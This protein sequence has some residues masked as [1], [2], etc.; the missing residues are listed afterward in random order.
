MCGAEK[1]ANAG[2][3]DTAVGV[4][5]GV[6]VGVLGSGVD[7]G[8][9]DAEG[10]V[11]TAAVGAAVD[12]H[13]TITIAVTVANAAMLQ[14]RSPAGRDAARQGALTRE[15]RDRSFMGA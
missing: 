4:G 8:V 12:E 15:D 3:V 7:C 14:A 13:A 11:V 2:V 9:G 10:L 1:L 6:G 5:A